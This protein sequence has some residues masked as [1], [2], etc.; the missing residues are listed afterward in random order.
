MVCENSTMCSLISGSLTMHQA[1]TEPVSEPDDNE[2]DVE[3]LSPSL[4]E[5]PLR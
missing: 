4:N 3:A 1:D 2:E 5:S